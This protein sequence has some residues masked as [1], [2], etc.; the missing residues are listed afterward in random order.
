MSRWVAGAALA[1][2]LPVA[3]TAQVVAITG[4]TVYP[5]SGP[6]IRNGTVVIRDGRIAAVGAD[7]PVPAGAERVDA[8]GKWVTPGLVNAGTQLGL[9]D[10]G[11]GAGPRETNARTSDG[12]AASFR[13]WDGFNPHSVLIAPAREDG[14]TSVLSLPNGGLVAG[15]AAVFDLANGTASDMV[16]R[17]P[18]VMVAQ[19]GDA[20]SAQAGARGQLLA[21]LR[22]LLEDTRWY[23]RHKADFDR[24]AAR[25]L[26]AGR[27][28]LEA[29]VPVVEGRLPLLISADRASDILQALALAREYGLRIIIGGGAEAWEVAPQIAAAKV[30]VLAGAMMDIPYDFSALGSR[31]DN[32][33]LLRKAGVTVGLIGNAGSGDEESFNVRNI[34]YE[35]GNAVGYG[36]SWDDALSAITLTPAEILGVADRVGA[37]RPGAE[38]NVV[39]WDGDPFEFATRVVAVFVRGVR[40]HDVSRQDLL[41]QRYRTLP[42]AYEKGP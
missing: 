40:Y 21:K 5:V 30:P 15:Q 17:A 31:Y 38:A 42:P 33:A 37:L 36:M 22:G 2:A 32:V 39:I 34:R 9:V 24:A 19:I 18:S 26:S 1:A 12:I 23:A 8:T 10:V 41:T 13:S 20:A 4:G 11:F 3:L 25:P 7:V 14:V 27:A 35:A 6:P 28:E 16:I 29:M